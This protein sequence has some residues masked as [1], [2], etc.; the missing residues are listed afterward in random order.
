MTT[1]ARMIYIIIYNVEYKIKLDHNKNN[2]YNKTK[3]S[4]KIIVTLQE[5]LIQIVNLISLT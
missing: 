3:T 1:I 4:K 2:T 5:K